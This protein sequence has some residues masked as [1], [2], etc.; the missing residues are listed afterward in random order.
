[1][2]RVIPLYGQVSRLFGGDS[3]FFLHLF[4]KNSRRSWAGYSGNPP[5]RFLAVRESNDIFSI[6]SRSSEEYAYSRENA[7][8]HPSQRTIQMQSIANNQ[9]LSSLRESVHSAQDKGYLKFRLHT[10]KYSF[11]AVKSIQIAGSLSAE[12]SSSLTNV[13]GKY[14]EPLHF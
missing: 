12:W 11:L 2:R 13:V 7:S 8:D 1:M 9:A 10:V 6:S 4:C 14:K 5:L 3:A